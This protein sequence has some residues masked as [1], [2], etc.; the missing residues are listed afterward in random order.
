MEIEIKKV[1]KGEVLL[2][3]ILRARKRS[4]TKGFRA[5]SGLKASKKVTFI[6]KPEKKPLKIKLKKLCLGYKK[7]SIKGKCVCYIF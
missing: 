2:R 7:N 5:I 1:D 4:L 6:D 3:S